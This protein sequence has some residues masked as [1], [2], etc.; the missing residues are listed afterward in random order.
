L[1]ALKLKLTPED[2]AEVREV[3][4]KADTSNGPRY[5]PGMADTLFAETPAWK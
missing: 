1:G 2:I 3:A 5:P 4:A